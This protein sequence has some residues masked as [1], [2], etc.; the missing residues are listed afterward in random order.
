M[1]QSNVFV[2]HIFNFFSYSLRVV[3][4]DFFLFLNDDTVWFLLSSLL[5]VVILST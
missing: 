5:V 2:V 4:C 1:I 3:L